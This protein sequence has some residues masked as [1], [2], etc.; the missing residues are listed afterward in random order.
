MRVAS[1][2]VWE[3]ARSIAQNCKRVVIICL[4]TLVFDDQCRGIG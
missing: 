2:A 1:G 3:T 4:K